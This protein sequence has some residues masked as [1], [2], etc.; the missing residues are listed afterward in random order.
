MRQVAFI[1]FRVCSSKYFDKCQPV[2]LSSAV[3]IKA[4]GPDNLE[5]IHL[6]KQFHAPHY[7]CLTLAFT[8]KEGS[9]AG[10]DCV[11]CRWVYKLLDYLVDQSLKA[12]PQLKHSLLMKCIQSDPLCE[13]VITKAMKNAAVFY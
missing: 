10:I 8:G 11:Q 12:L 4:R 6:H 3:Q 1:L 7:S 2:K 5:Y 9:M 13:G